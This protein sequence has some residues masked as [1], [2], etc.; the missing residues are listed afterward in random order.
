MHQSIVPL[1]ADELSYTE[2]LEPVVLSI[3]VIT[4]H[5]I[6][7]CCVHADDMNLNDA[8]L[9]VIFHVP[10][11]IERLFDDNDRY[12]SATQQSILS[13]THHSQEI[14][15]SFHADIADGGVSLY[16]HARTSIRCAH[17][18]IAEDRSVCVHP[19]GATIA[20]NQ[21]FAVIHAPS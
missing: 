10:Q 17:E 9:F 12:L 14:D 11:I 3:V 15:I 5:D 4:T 8:L 1:L 19:V 6:L 13:T 21:L 2:K 16:V 7:T 18:L 20:S